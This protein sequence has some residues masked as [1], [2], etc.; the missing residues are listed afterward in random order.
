MSGSPKLTSE[1]PY[2]LSPARFAKFLQPTR[3][4]LADSFR[5]VVGI[6]CHHSS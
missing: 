6:V 2:L 1:G 4:P 3:Q 5:I